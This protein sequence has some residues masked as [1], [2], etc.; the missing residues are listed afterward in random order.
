[1]SGIAELFTTSGWAMADISQKRPT[2]RRAL[3]MGSIHVGPVA[4][5]HV[6][7]GTLPKGDALKLAEIAGLQG[8]KNA[9]QAIPLCH[10]VA[11]DHVA[12]VF[13]PQKASHSVSV[14][15]L[16]VAEARTGVEMEALAGVLA[17][18]LTIYDLTKPVEPALSLGETRLLFKQGGK[19]GLWV[20]PQGVPPAVARLLP[21]PA[22]PLGSVAA[23]VLTLSDRAFAGHYTDRSGPLVQ[24]LLEEAGAR[25]R[26]HRVLPDS[27]ELL[28][29][30]L[31]I[32]AGSVDLI[33][34]TG[35]TGLGQRDITCDVLS[36]LPGARPVPG[37]GELLRSDG[38][39]ATPNAWLSR[40][41]AVVWSNTL[42]VALPGSERAVREGLA[43]IGGILPHA[44]E[45]IAGKDHE[46]S[47]AAEGK[48]PSDD[49]LS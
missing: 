33:V 23:D 1:M 40:S 29:T 15:C 46:P 18:L 21:A 49:S 16:A 2:L 44:L 24:S 22:R 11:L 32:A 12:L 34:T 42:I 5:P 26:S 13:E 17:A 9:S 25:V 47:R 41:L 3:A 35:G 36:S 45:M 43:A 14:Y 7:D 19:K 28:R 6:R 30:H 4:Y 38:A 39:R 31:M 27:H 10:P 37:F 8:A 20:H 48:D